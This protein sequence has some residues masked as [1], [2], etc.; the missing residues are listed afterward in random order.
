MDCG[1]IKQK[2]D[3]MKTLYDLRK[4]KQVPDNWLLILGPNDIARDFV[5]YK[6][7]GENFYP[8]ENKRILQ[9]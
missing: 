8:L 4:Y 7:D 3:Y 6:F 9:Q 1:T 5:A 2:L